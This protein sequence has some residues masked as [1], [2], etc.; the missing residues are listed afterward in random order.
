MN[1]VN[2]FILK[3]VE[4]GGFCITDNNQV[5]CEESCVKKG[6][7]VPFMWGAREWTGIVMEFSS[8]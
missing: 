6:D 8:E 7:E 5:I 3:C 2:M 1:S 4:D